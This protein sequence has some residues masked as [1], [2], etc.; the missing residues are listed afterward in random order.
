MVEGQMDSYPN[1]SNYAKESKLDAKEE[2]SPKKIEKV[3]EGTVIRRKKPLGKR[4]SEMF[5]GGDS[6]T[7]GAYLLY[8]VLLPATKDTLA[9][10]MSQGVERMLFGEVQSTSRRPGRRGSGQNYV[11]Y[12][13]YSGSR[14]PWEN[15][16]EEPRKTS[17]AVQARPKFDEIIV[18]TRPEAEEVIQ[19]MFDLIE[20]YESATVADLYEL[21]G[22]PGEYT[23]DKWGWTE[24]RGA[25]ITRITRGYLLNLPNPEPLD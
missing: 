10:L 13:R 20:R 11:S 25:G 8:D 17:R 22:I 19:R 14:P 12:N 24:L 6:R 18:Q 21:V 7:V 1:N 2:A 15:R 5:I 3:I 23:D 16:R 4:I 9:D